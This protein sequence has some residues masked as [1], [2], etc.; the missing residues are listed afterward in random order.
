MT[1][2]VIPPS[3]ASNTK[4]YDP[5]QYFTEE[6]IANQ[7]TYVD[8]E[9]YN[10]V[11]PWEVI[12]QI[13]RSPMT[14]RSPIKEMIQRFNAITNWTLVTILSQNTPKARA[15]LYSKFVKI[16]KVGVLEH[17]LCARETNLPVQQ[18]REMN[19]FNGVMAIIGALN[20]K[21]ITRLTQTRSLLSKRTQKA[22][23]K[24]DQ[25]LNMRG[26]FR[27][28]R[29][30]LADLDPPAI[31]FMGLILSDYTF[32]VEGNASAVDGMINFSQRKLMWTNCLEL[33][34]KFQNGSEA[35]APQHWA[36]ERLIAKTPQ[37][38]DELA[39]ERSCAIEPD[40][41]SV[42]RDDVSSISIL[43]AKTTERSTSTENNERS[44]D[45]ALSSSK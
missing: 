20:N 28:Y 18:L 5:V 10:A 11:Q 32:I 41:E 39:F 21:A 35:D 30:L 36:A 3:L 23:E 4:V 26:N 25:L 13:W 34:M 29:D 12:R 2:D 9:V 37:W 44:E 42:R 45:L 33:L 27:S 14:T 16:A 40:G 7:I 1:T 31:P 24:L 8:Y 6:D 38:T 43:A 19:N 15:Q 17:I 22:L